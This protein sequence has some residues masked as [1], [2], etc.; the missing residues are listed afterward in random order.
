MYISF[1]CIV[2]VPIIRRYNC[3]YA[4][5]GICHSVWMIVWYAGSIPPCIPLHS[6]V[7]SS[8]LRPKILL[9]TLC[10]DT[11]SLRSCLNVSDQVSRTYKTKGLLVCFHG[12]PRQATGVLQPAGLLYRPIWKF[13]LWPPDAPAPTDAFRTLAVEVGTYGRE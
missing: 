7:N 9:N 8:L 11:C 1:L 12:C 13:Q 2:Y 3:I 5:L 4:T 10:S 6:P